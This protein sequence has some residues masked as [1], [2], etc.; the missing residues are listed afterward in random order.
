MATNFVEP[1][2][3]YGP[4]TV[5]AQAAAVVGVPVVWGILVGV[6]LANAASAAN[7]V[8]GTGGVWDITKVN[9]ASNAIAFG[10]NVYWDATNS[11]AT[12]SATSNARI[13]Q[14][15]VAA[16]TADTKV[17]VLLAKRTT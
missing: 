4:I 17:R 14:A 15:V 1:A 10:A 3:D 11:Q 9:A 7:V 12:A 5:V 2:G 16:L 13:G 8:L 6:P